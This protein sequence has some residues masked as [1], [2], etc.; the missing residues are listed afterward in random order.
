M[1]HIATGGVSD[2][3]F[4]VRLLRRQL[5]H[6]GEAVRNVGVVVLKLAYNA[7]ILK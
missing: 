3:R 6:T 2:D 7:P 5:V 1:K 4:N